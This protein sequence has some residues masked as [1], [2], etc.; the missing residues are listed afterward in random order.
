MACTHGG[1]RLRRNRCSAA[2]ST[3]R[4]NRWNFAGGGRWISVEGT[5]VIGSAE[6]IDKS[7][8]QPAVV[9]LHGSIYGRVWWIRS[10]GGSVCARVKL[11]TAEHGALQQLKMADVPVQGVALYVCFHASGR[12]PSTTGLESYGAVRF[13]DGPP[14]MQTSGFRPISA[15]LG[16]LRERLRWVDFPPVRFWVT[17]ASK[18]TSSALPRIERACHGRLSPPGFSS[19][20][21]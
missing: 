9:L 7:A 15:T 4:F 10:R 16:R 3:S 8:A 2:T 12:V 11:G 21:W 17:D 20:M 1:D 5:T 6:L 19:S 18:R 13:S 14:P